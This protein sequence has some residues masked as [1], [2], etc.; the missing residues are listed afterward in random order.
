M[1]LFVMLCLIIAFIICMKK[2]NYDFKGIELIIFWLT[3]TCCIFSKS[4]G[5]FYTFPII[6]FGIYYLINVIKT[7][8]YIKWYMLLIQFILSII[9]L[10]GFSVY[11]NATCDGMCFG[12]LILF[13]I[14][15]GMLSYMLIINL[16]IFVIN[17]ITNKQIKNSNTKKLNKTSLILIIIAI[18]I[19]AFLLFKGTIIT[20]ET[21]LDTEQYFLTI[22]SNTDGYGIAGNYIEGKIKTKIIPIDI[23]N[24]IDED[25]KLNNTKSNTPVLKIVGFYEERVLLEVYEW[26]EWKTM[27]LNYNEEYNY[28]PG[29]TVITDGPVLDITIKIERKMTNEK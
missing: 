21:P 25:L 28:V 5:D 13:L 1:I 15:I 4:I 6:F 17:K 27:F 11:E 26:N 10:I 24:I 7:K 19:G 22:E 8:K 29:Y 23:G 2:F 9:F 20:T 3:F 12:S 18:V 16:I 14:F